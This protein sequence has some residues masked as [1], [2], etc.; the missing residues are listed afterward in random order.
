MDTEIYVILLPKMDENLNLGYTIKIGFSKNFENRLNQGYKTYYSYVKILHRYKGNFTMEDETKLKKYFKEYLLSKDEYYEYCPEIIDFFNIY[1]TSDKLKQKLDSFPRKVSATFSVNSNL[2]EYVIIKKYSNNDFI[3]K[4]Q[5]RD[6]LYNCLKRY[7]LSSQYKYVCEKYNIEKEDILLYLN[8]C[9]EFS[10]NINETLK[11][12]AEEFSRLGSKDRLKYLT[13]LH[14]YIDKSEIDIFFQLIP[15]RFKDY[16]NIIGIN[17]IKSCRS[18][19]EL[20]KKWINYLK[21]KNSIDLN[22]LKNDIISSFIVGETYTT[23]KIK[24]MLN[25]IYFKYSYKKTV[26]ATNLKEYFL[27]KPTSISEF[28]KYKNGFKIL[29]IL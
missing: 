14:E 24:L 20:K 17:I 19:K 7:K 6:D 15:P 26:H 8:I 28:G 5:K 18:E 23:Q 2:I 4:Q 10:F 12:K 1:N 29:E 16:Y 21:D 22:L 9:N 13:K 3:D 11:R 27:L 25:D